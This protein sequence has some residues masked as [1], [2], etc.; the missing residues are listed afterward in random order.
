MGIGAIGGL[1]AQRFA[2]LGFDVRGWARSPR[3]IDNVT[4][5]AGDNGLAP[6]LDGLEILV[7]VLPLTSATTGIMNSDMF[8]QLAPGA[9]IINGGRGPQ[10]VEDDLLDAI[11][12]GQIA[13][14]AAGCVYNRAIAS[15]SPILGAPSYYCLASCCSTNQP[16][17]CGTAGCCR[18]N[19]HHDRK[20]TRQPR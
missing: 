2:A 5:F 8:N 9:Y 6:F 3:E 4:V 16:K 17:Y 12:R 14:A 18:D 7:S 15:K 20:G 19:C 13:G 10:L 11:D 1:T